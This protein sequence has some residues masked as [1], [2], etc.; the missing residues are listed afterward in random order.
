VLWRIVDVRL[1]DALVNGVAYSARNIGGALRLTQ[2]GVAPNY[3]V[4]VVLG[5]VAIFWWLL[6]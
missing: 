1:I 6:F 2:N 3:A 5:A 4:G